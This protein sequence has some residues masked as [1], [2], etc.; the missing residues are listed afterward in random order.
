MKKTKSAFALCLFVLFA[1]SLYAEATPSPLPGATPGY[2][3]GAF[4]LNSKL[5]SLNSRLASIEN[6]TDAMAKDMHSM[7]SEITRT[8][9]L[10][11][12]QTPA[13]LL[14]ALCGAF[15]T[16]ILVFIGVREIA[17]KYAVQLM[18]RM[19]AAKEGEKKPV[20]IK[21]AKRR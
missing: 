15:A 5:D 2:D 21:K 9:S 14:V 8:S 3:S 7:K 19:I 17:K 4:A 12:T 13:N 11:V 18:E 6:D 10:T 20:E 16:A 1:C